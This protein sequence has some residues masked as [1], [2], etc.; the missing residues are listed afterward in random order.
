ME[1]VGHARERMAQR[2]LAEEDVEYAWSHTVAPSQPGRRPDTVKFVGQ[3]AAGRRLVI[4]VSK[5]D[6]RRI[7]SVWPE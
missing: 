3:T 4:V 5:F 6:R 2:G 7:I 1:F